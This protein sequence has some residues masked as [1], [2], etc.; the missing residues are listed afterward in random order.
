M[1]NIK[2]PT[3]QKS[4][5]KIA[6]VITSFLAVIGWILNSF[7]AEY[8]DDKDKSFEELKTLEKQIEWK[9]SQSFRQK[10]M[11]KAI[12]N[13]IQN[14]T[15]D[16]FQSM[17][18]RYEELQ[19][20]NH[21][22]SDLA[23]MEVDVVDLK[24][25]AKD[26]LKAA[27]S[28][29]TNLKYKGIM[30]TLVPKIDS[31]HEDFKK[32]FLP[33]DGM[34]IQSVPIGNQILKLDTNTL[35]VNLKIAKKLDSCI[36]SIDLVHRYLVYWAVAGFVKDSSFANDYKDLGKF[37]TRSKI[38]KYASLFLSLLTLIFSIAEKYRKV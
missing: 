5:Y 22:S 4:F 34:T 30:D 2:S 38:I 13:V 33:D 6:S 21:R 16:K 37:G 26:I 18:I 1:L 15:P 3:K 20:L 9:T 19:R 14:E 29:N 31:L 27:A 12:L 11:Q 8:Y 17:D 28:S 36:D 32:C 10:N 23:M 25:T 7:L 35:K 24:E